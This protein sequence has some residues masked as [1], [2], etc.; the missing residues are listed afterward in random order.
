[1]SDDKT[2]L[3]DTTG[4]NCPLPVLKAEKALKS[5]AP[6]A[7]LRVLAS[8]PLSVIDIPH[9]CQSGGHDLVASHQH[10]NVFVFDIRR[11]EN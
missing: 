1:M 11:G 10:E 6:G 7:S 4:L 5:M 8:D 2:E 9:M 3:L